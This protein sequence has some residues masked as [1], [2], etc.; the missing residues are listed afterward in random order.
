MKARLAIL[1]RL[2]QFFSNLIK[3]GLC[4]ASVRRLIE[5]NIKY[6]GHT[7]PEED[8]DSLRKQDK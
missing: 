5:H 1:T 4:N 7:K 3:T 6:S 2:L 8:R